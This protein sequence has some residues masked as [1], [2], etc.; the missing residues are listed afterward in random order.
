M[1]GC[2]VRDGVLCGFGPRRPAVGGR[3]REVDV[4]ALVIQT[5][6]LGLE[7][8]RTVGSIPHHRACAGPTLKYRALA[9]QLAEV[10]R[11]SWRLR[12]SL[13]VWGLRRVYGLGRSAQHR[14]NLPFFGS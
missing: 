6:R 10:F 12:L 1:R 9:W 5:L 7:I 11:R 14:C 3:C 2:I 4:A 13:Q 8:S